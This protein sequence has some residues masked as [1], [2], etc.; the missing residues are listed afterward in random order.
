MKNKFWGYFK[1]GGKGVYQIAPL[2]RSLIE[3]QPFRNKSDE[4]RALDKMVESHGVRWLAAYDDHTENREVFVI[5]DLKNMNVNV[6]FKLYSTD[7][8]YEKE[9]LGIVK[10]LNHSH[11]E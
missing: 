5:Y 10:L 4:S 2:P 7:G 6:K 8:C 9:A 3:P 1:K 11:R